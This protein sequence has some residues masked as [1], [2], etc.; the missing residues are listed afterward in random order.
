MMDTDEDSL[1]SFIPDFS[2]DDFA[3]VKW[4]QE[5]RKTEAEFRKMMNDSIKIVADTFNAKESSHRNLKH[6]LLHK[7]VHIPFIIHS[8]Q[9]RWKNRSIYFCVF[10]YESSVHAG[11]VHNV[12]SNYYFAGMIELD[13]TYPHTM[14]QPE[15][16][17]LKIEDLFTRLDTDFEHAKK[18]SRKFYLITKD[19][20]LLE[21]LF[22]NKDLDRLAV[23][24]T[25][26]F[27]L[28]DKQCY[29]RASR[30]PVSLDEAEEFAD[31]AKTLLE[32][33]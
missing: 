1:D 18:F 12:G 3:D 32:V 20:P 2:G 33:I 21:M 19:E 4:I 31:L 6:F 13:R 15:T 8:Y 7:S 23:F 17:A 28:K 27:E 25:A 5:K 26:E 16:I 29:F 14:A 10:E 24:N 11:R 9:G 22:L 30:K